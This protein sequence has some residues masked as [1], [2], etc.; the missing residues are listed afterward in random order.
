MI[1]MSGEILFHLL[2]G[3]HAVHARHFQVE[4]HD[5]PVPFLDHI[6]SLITAGRGPH[7]EPVLAQPI[8]HG[9]TNRGFIVHNQDADFFSHAV[10]PPS[11]CRVVFGFYRQINRKG[12]AFP[13]TLVHFYLPPMAG[14]DPVNHGKTQS[15][16]LAFRLG[17][18]KG[19]E[20]MSQIFFGNAVAGIRYIDSDHFC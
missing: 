18:G 9:I 10:P 15:H 12:G 6:D 8:S 5:V 1:S 3:L 4:Q 14:D 11:D 17:G 2:H 19:F 7:L 13:F 20:Y 16:A